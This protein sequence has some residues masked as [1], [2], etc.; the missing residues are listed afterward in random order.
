MTKTD[1]LWPALITALTAVLYLVLVINVGRAR[2]KYGVMPPATTG[3]EDF[4][5]VL[6]VQYNTL[7]Q[8]A[9]FLPGL[10]LFAIYRDPIIASILGGLWILGRILYAWGYYRAAEKR[11]VGFALGSLSSIIL[12]LGALLSILW[13]LGQISQF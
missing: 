2:A 9:L 11:M 1:L 3:N 7:E 6:R 8:L 5:R 13:Q 12:V 4:E 10:W